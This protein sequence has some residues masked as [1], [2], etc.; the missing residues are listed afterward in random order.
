MN[1]EKIITW[2]KSHK[3]ITILILFGLFLI[4]LIVVH[5]LFKWHSGCTYFSAEWSAGDLI[6]YIS[7]F[8]VFTI[9]IILGIIAVR[10][11]DQ[12]NKTNNNILL[13]TKESERNSVLPFLSFNIYATKY[14][15]YSILSLLA[16]TKPDGEIDEGRSKFVPLEDTA[17]RVDFLTSELFN[18]ISADQIKITLELSKDQKEKIKYQFGIEKQTDNSIAI[19]DPDYFY[20]ILCIENCGKGSAINTKYRLYKIGKESNEKFNVYSNPFTIPVEKHFDLGFYIDLSE[21]VIGNYILEITYQDTMTH[22]YRQKVTFILGENS[23]SI[24]VSQIQERLN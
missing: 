20:K 4:P 1:I 13:Q 15:E 6:G 12:A 5:L 2:I 21:L 18:T 7:G 10:Q 17:N 23:C 24:D 8:E 9:T 19:T 11:S 3:I 22:I 16:K 14:E